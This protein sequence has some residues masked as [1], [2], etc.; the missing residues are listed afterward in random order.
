MERNAL[1]PV[2]AGPGHRSD[3][4]ERPLI[5]LQRPARHQAALW[6]VLLPVIAANGL[7][8]LDPIATS[9]TF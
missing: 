8:E 1:R 5:D 7:T 2:V 9:H 4:T 6:C 3:S